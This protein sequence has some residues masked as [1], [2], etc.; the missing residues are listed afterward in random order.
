MA[1]LSYTD[2][3][4]EAEEELVNYIL[5]ESEEIESRNLGYFTE[6]GLYEALH[7]RDDFGEARLFLGTDRKYF[8]VWENSEM[9]NNWSEI[10]TDI[11]LG[12][13]DTL[14]EAR[15]Y[16]NSVEEGERPPQEQIAAIKEEINEPLLWIDAKYSDFA[17]KYNIK[18]NYLMVSEK[19]LQLSAEK[20]TSD[21]E[22]FKTYL[23]Q[24]KSNGIE[25]NELY[26][27]PREWN[28][29][30]RYYK[31]SFEYKGHSIS[32][33][34]HIASKLQHKERFI[35]DFFPVEK[36]TA[37]AEQEYKTQLQARV[38]WEEDEKEI[39]ERGVPF[40][41][42]TAN[43]L[44]EYLSNRI[45]ISF[46]HTDCDG[47]L[48]YTKNFL[49]KKLRFEKDSLRYTEKWIQHHGGF[50]DCEVLMNVLDEIYWNK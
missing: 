10:N 34:A 24:L 40:D 26:K 8:F 31:M 45:H 47:T 23:E 46:G 21:L 2:L 12:I 3:G 16:Y 17:I 18:Y 6:E 39:A 42:D 38:Q 28:D 27:L 14:E 5:D 13:F 44:G 43:Q 19:V 37:F 33:T 22:K 32:M 11:D 20:V 35:P 30:Q 1:E 7:R 25:V 15:D 36:V 48:R 9:V 49:K 50:C 4:F 41:Y 29:N